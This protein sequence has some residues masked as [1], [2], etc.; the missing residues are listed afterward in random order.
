MTH[1]PAGSDFQ[2]DSEGYLHPGTNVG[3][4]TIDKVNTV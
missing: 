2:K 1:K 4:S 3:N